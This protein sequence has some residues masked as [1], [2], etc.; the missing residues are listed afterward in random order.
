M[1]ELFLVNFCLIFSAKIAVF[2]ASRTR[3]VF[4]LFGMSVIKRLKRV[5]E[6]STPCGRPSTGL[7]ICDLEL[8]NGMVEKK[9]C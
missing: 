7:L 6:R 8:P 5:S 2:S 4:G 9:E 3:F 1:D